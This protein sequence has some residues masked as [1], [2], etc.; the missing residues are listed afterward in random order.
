MAGKTGREFQSNHGACTVAL[1]NSTNNEILAI[2]SGVAQEESFPGNTAKTQ[3]LKDS[4][5]Q[6]AKS[7]EQRA[8]SKEQKQSIA[9]QIVT[10]KHT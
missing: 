7:K 10:L 9:F 6:R 4:K 1:W 5:T 3:R 2:K 8:K